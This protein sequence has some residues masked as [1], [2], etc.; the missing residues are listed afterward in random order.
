MRRNAEN[1][2][3]AKEAKEVAL[4]AVLIEMHQIILSDRYDDKGFAEGIYYL[5][6]EYLK[7]IGEKNGKN[8]LNETS[9]L[10]DGNYTAPI[11]HMLEVT[12]NLKTDHLESEFSPEVF[13]LVRQALRFA[14]LHHDDGKIFGL[15]SPEHPSRSVK[16]FKQTIELL[17]NEGL[18]YDENVIEMATDL[19]KRH[20]AY[21]KIAEQVL[22][23]DLLQR[24]DELR[25][26]LKILAKDCLPNFGL[27]GIVFF[28]KLMASI[29]N[30]N[31]AAWFEVSYPEIGEDY[32]LGLRIEDNFRISLVLNRADVLASDQFAP[33]YQINR[34]IFMVYLIYLKRYGEPELSRSNSQIGVSG[35]NGS[36]VDGN[37]NGN[38]DDLVQDFFQSVLNQQQPALADKP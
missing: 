37:G 12:R 2:E 4:I 20:H 18:I 13:R 30:L 31:F 25:L 3:K 15:T 35:D 14:A 9:E 23:E 38:G 36:V 8:I 6:A 29:E 22:P 5:Q 1:T 33:W 28:E 11:V 17:E 26:K 16:I 27:A 24:R 21:G 32:G 7:I 34:Q 10:S 19:I